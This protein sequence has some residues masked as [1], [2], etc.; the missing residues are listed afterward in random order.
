MA[1]TSTTVS[2]FKLEAVSVKWGREHC[3]S[4]KTVADVA[5]SLN[6]T[7]FDLN[8]PTTEYY[9]WF[10]VGAGGT[11]PAIAGKTGIEVALTANDAA[12]VVASAIQVA[13][14]A[15]ADFSSIVSTSD[16]ELVLIE[17]AE[18]GPVTAETDSGS[19]GFT[20]AV[21]IE[22]IGG[23][24]GSTAQGGVTISSETQVFDV[25][26]D[27]TGQTL[28]DQI[29]L[30]NT[31]TAELGLIEITPARLAT[32]IGGVVGDTGT[33]SGGT[34]VTGIG[35]SKLYQSL[36]NLG[37]KLILHPIRLPESDKSRDVIFWKS[38]PKPQ[39][40]NYSGQ[41]LQTLSVTFD[42]Y[43]DT[44]VNS[45]FNL[46]MFGDYTQDLTGL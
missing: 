4:V 33:P 36:A 42:A 20:L 23:D 37:G 25:F 14:D 34:V 22:G 5:S 18:I 13:V 15:E 27:Q 26:S 7:Y 40:I 1:L 45:K 30:G 44:S 12:S 19:T 38:A 21:L 28:L 17:N 10:N 9:V 24:L 35:E 43:R 11:D 6:N 32:V 29:N 2:E 41:D 8:T 31:A 3:R 16:N 39:S 46:I